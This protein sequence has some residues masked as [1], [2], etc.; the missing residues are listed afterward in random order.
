MTTTTRRRLH[1]YAAGFF[2][3]QVPLAIWL[4]HADP[5]LF[6]V[7]WRQYLIFISLYAIVSTHLAAAAAETPFDDEE[8][9][10]GGDS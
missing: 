5:A 10:T 1:Y 3:V 2:A 4:Q 6:E 7:W 9:V 8:E